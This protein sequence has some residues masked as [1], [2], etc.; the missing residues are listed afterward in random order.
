MRK[1]IHP[2]YKEVTV[3]CGCGNTFKTRST[4]ET[5]LVEI[6][7][8]CHPFYTG[9]QKFVD[10][11]GMVEKFQRKWT[12]QAAKEAKDKATKP[13]KKG[14]EVKMPA[15]SAKTLQSQL[16]GA[17]PASLA[18]AVPQKTAQK[19]IQPVEPKPEAKPE[20]PS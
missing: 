15:R 1:G 7:S 12:S 9:K 20:K 6:C 18:P 4:K 8:N 17:G 3:K 10:T 11:A 13:V 5:I 14:L 2:D 19:A 16:P